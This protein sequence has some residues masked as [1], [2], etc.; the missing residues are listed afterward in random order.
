MNITEI[1]L[2]INNGGQSTLITLSATSAQ[3]PVVVQPAGL[4]VGVPVPCVV[5]PDVNC[6]AR[7]GTNPTAVQDSD[8]KLLAGNTY[9]IQLMA[10]E[11]LALVAAG[12]GTANFTPNA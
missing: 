9:R 11:R 10:G 5:T 8:I 3:G 7:K 1:T 6:W 12:A 4:P 2:D